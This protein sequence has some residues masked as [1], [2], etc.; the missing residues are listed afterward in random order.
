MNLI[1][2]SYFPGWTQGDYTS[3]DSTIDDS[4][5]VRQHMNPEEG[6]TKRK[7][8]ADIREV[9]LSKTDLITLMENLSGF[10]VSSCD[11]F[12]ELGVC[13][14]DVETIGLSSEQYGFA[15]SGPILTL[16]QST[17]RDEDDYDFEILNS[18]YRLW[19]FFD[20]IQPHR[21]QAHGKPK[22]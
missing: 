10:D 11:Y 5:H 4:G 19:R 8:G 6:K 9:Q 18:L 14:D 2:Y 21:F 13:I 17:R 20:K 3:C 16:W 12:K 1:R 7:H 15:V 22:R